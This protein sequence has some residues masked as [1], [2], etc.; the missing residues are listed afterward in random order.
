MEN[1]SVNSCNYTTLP[2]EEKTGTSFRKSNNLPNQSV[3]Y[4]KKSNKKKLNKKI[5]F[6]TISQRP[7]II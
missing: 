5:N 1:L 2:T 6:S 3:H 4:E 7:M